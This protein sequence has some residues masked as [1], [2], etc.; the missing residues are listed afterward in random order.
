MNVHVCTMNVHQVTMENI[1][2]VL[3]IM[4]IWNDAVQSQLMYG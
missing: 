2:M 1:S 3:N 4:I